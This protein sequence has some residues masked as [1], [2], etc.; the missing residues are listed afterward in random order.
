MKSIFK[1]KM[2]DDTF[3]K[4]KRYLFITLVSFSISYLV[5]VIRNSILWFM[6]ANYEDKSSLQKQHSD[7][8]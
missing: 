3:K 8:E 5:D 7:F 6:L 4:E 2:T 1:E